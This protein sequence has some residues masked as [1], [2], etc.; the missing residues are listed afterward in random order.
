MVQAIA[1]AGLPLQAIESGALNFH[2]RKTPTP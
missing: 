2:F 1:I